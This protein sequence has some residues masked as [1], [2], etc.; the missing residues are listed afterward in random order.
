VNCSQP[1]RFQPV[2]GRQVIDFDIAIFM[3]KWGIVWTTSLSNF[4]NCISVACQGGK[5]VSSSMEDHVSAGTSR[6]VQ[7]RSSTDR[8]AASPLNSG[9]DTSPHVSAQRKVSPSASSVAS[10]PK[11]GGEPDPQR[12]DSPSGTD[13]SPTSTAGTYA[14][15][16]I[17]TGDGE[18]MRSVLISPIV[19]Q[20]DTVRASAGISNFTP[21]VANGFMHEDD[22]RERNHLHPP[23]LT[24]S[25]LLPHSVVLSWP[26]MDNVLPLE[27]TDEE[28]NFEVEEWVIRRCDVTK[29]T[30]SMEWEIV[31]PDAQ[32]KGS[33]LDAGLVPQ[34]RYKYV[35]SRKLAERS[36]I[37]QLPFVIITTPMS[38]LESVLFRRPSPPRSRR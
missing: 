37:D 36:E 25:S 38:E 3:D 32:W 24:P 10:S 4:A 9:H 6:P 12:S 27:V 35:L 7:K 20:S 33:Y 18:L 13:H 16:N 28:P 5:G 23:P 29:R 21:P 2:R 34:H 30:Q 15:D 19:A 17:S 8:Y 14:V 26:F 1:C 31:C 22:V 11:I